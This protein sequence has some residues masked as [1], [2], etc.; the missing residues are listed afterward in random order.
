L[1]CQWLTRQ[2]E[3]RD[4]GLRDLLV[5]LIPGASDTFHRHLTFILEQLGKRR[6][7]KCPSTQPWVW[8]ESKTGM[9]EGVASPPPPPPPVVSDSTAEQSDVPSDDEGDEDTDV[10]DTSQDSVKI[11]PAPSPQPPP[12][13]PQPPAAVMA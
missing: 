8:L 13:N 3:A 2:E 5:D 12:P 10:D 4:C 1:V 7:P 6:G 9:N 11:T